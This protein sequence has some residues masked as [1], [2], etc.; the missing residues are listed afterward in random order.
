MTITADQ[1]WKTYKTIG[2]V[3]LGV[4]AAATAVVC[5]VLPYTGQKTKKEEN[6]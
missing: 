2:N 3:V 5:F 6:A 4:A 1:S